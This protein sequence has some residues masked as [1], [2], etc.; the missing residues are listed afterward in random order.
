MLP[1]G[2]FN[3][4]TPIPPKTGEIAIEGPI[5]RGIDVEPFTVDIGI[6]TKGR[7]VSNFGAD[8]IRG[9]ARNYIQFI[10]VDLTPDAE[11]RGRI[12]GFD[13]FR[14]PSQAQSS[15]TLT[16]EALTPGHTYGFLLLMGHW[17]R[18]YEKELDTANPVIDGS[19]AYVYKSELPTL[20]VSGFTKQ[21][22][23]PN[24]NKI[25]V[26]MYPLVVDTVFT[27]GTKTVHPAITAGKPE[28]AYLSPGTWTAE[29]TLKTA[30]DTG[31]GLAGLIEAQG[32][33][34]S[35]GVSQD[36]I[37]R[38]T[39]IL[40]EEGS[41]AA[42]P[43]ASVSMV[44]TDTTKI[45]LSP[46]LTL[47]Q[48]LGSKGSVNFKLEYV[49][50]GL[51]NASAWSACKG[52]GPDKTVA[53]LEGGVPVWII[54]N[55]VN[56]DEQ[57][58]KTDFAKLGTPDF[59]TMAQDK[60]PNGNG[61]VRFVAG[62]DPANPPELDPTLAV[63]KNGKFITGK[64]TDTPTIGFTLDGGYAGTA[65][66]YYAAVSAG[67]GAPADLAAYS[68]GYLGEFGSG[69]SPQDLNITLK[70]AKNDVWLIAFKDNKRSNPCKIPRGIF[71]G[72]TSTNGAY[73]LQYSEDGGETW[74]SNTNNVINPSA[75][76]YGNGKFM[77]SVRD[78]TTA[79]TVAVST[80]GK[81]WTLKDPDKQGTSNFDP[82]A[83]AYGGGYFVIIDGTGKNY[84]IYSNGNT[85]SNTITWAK[86]AFMP[87]VS[88]GWTRVKYGD[89]LFL[90]TGLGA[91][92][93]PYSMYSMDHGRTWAA[94]SGG[95]LDEHSGQQAKTVYGDKKFVILN[96]TGTVYVFSTVTK[97]W[98][99]NTSLSIIDKGL[100]PWK[101]IT[102][103]G[104]GRFLA[105]RKDG[106]IGWSD[107]DL[108]W[109]ETDTLKGTEE[110]IGVTYG[111][112]RF[113]A[114]T[115]GGLIYASPDGITWEKISSTGPKSSFD[116]DYL[117]Y[118]EP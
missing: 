8:R 86:A 29:W 111:G 58:D 70:A 33:L 105:V 16:C 89:N 55:G 110:F 74:Y 3:A 49:P 96:T 67:A 12:A 4:L 83:M 13:E 101:G 71:I 57:D 68:T 20:L 60:L 77:T 34:S 1:S 35:V 102:Y 59:R 26:K 25:E 44:T 69:D 53:N 10:A 54:R 76:A 47:P 52:G 93:T 9:N 41:A 99:F 98:T 21:V 61:A 80:D 23:E 100:T 15:Y 50:F 113:L 104:S 14:R 63:I 85:K 109:N 73:N 106:R 38:K 112:G 72:L 56:D 40:R 79:A 39:G 19:W 30:A 114:G 11:S 78:N 103:D 94:P 64:D 97:T 92:S 24:T 28:P 18:D 46:E 81:K 66:V 82:Y 51:N 31:S 115:A 37:R 2:C 62:V 5:D 22:I 45:T 91:A 108:S 118:A 65:L 43:P 117:F 95:G 17:D 84:P 116:D 27:Q 107:N 42:N 75:V 36:V 88:A 87:S 7:S 90:A 6:S 48:T 32:E